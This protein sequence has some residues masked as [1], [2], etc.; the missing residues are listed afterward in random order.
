MHQKPGERNLVCG[1]YVAKYGNGARRDGL[2]DPLSTVKATPFFFLKERGYL[3][4]RDPSSGH[5]L[6][7]LEMECV[8]NLSSFCKAQCLYKCG[9]LSWPFPCCHLPFVWTAKTKYKCKVMQGLTHWIGCI[10]AQFGR[11]IAPVPC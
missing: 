7:G 4:G 10:V 5:R 2:D 1:A 6:I 9:P 8:Q 11:V 3:A